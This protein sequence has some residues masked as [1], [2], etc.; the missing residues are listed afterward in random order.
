MNGDLGHP[1][2]EADRD[3]KRRQSLGLDKHRFDA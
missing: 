3:G 1:E 2:G